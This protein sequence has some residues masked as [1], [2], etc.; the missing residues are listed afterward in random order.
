MADGACPKKLGRA[1]RFLLTV[2]KSGVEYKHN[3]RRT[4]ATPMQEEHKPYEFKTAAHAAK[5]ASGAERLDD[6][7]Y[8]YKVVG[9]A[10]K[11][12]IEVTRPNGLKYLM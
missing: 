9:A 5:V 8:S 4:R 10:G 7:G 6:E 11:F 1:P 3:R 2:T 12:H